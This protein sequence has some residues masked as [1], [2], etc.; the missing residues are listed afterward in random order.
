MLVDADVARLE[1][2][3]AGAV[4]AVEAVEVGAEELVVVVVV[5]HLELA[6]RER[7]EAL[8]LLLGTPVDGGAVDEGRHL[9]YLLARP[10]GASL[11]Q[12][13]AM[14]MVEST[15]KKGSTETGF[16]MLGRRRIFC[17]RTTEYSAQ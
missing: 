9:V 5:L 1:A 4:P 6:E 11:D 14:K 15:L 17:T 2:L 16:S 3:L 12:V 10:Q 7:P 8:G 13:Q